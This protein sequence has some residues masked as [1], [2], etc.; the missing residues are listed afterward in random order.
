MREAPNPVAKS[1][2]GVATVG[3]DPGGDEGEEGQEQRS[4]RQFV[5]LTRREG[6]ADG[7]AGGVGDHASLGPVT[8]ARTAQRLMRVALR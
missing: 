7:A 1:V 8:A 3:H 4:Q 6:E 5:R 2:A